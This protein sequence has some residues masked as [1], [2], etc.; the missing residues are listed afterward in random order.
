MQTDVVREALK[1]KVSKEEYAEYLHEKLLR[2]CRKDPNQFIQSVMSWGMGSWIPQGSLHVKW[3]NALTTGGKRVL[4]ICPRDHAKTSQVAIGRVLWELGNNPDLRI[5]IVCQSDDTAVKRLSAIIDHIDRNPRL[6]EVFPDL[7]PSDK[8]T[9]SK[10]KVYV[11]RNMILPD[12]SIEAVG[13]LSTATGGRGDLLIFD[14][15]VDFRNAIQQPALREVVKAAY[16]DVWVNLIEPEGRIVLIGTPWHKDDL[17]H[18]IMTDKTYTKIIDRIDDKFTPIWPEK[19]NT[20]A[21]VNRYNEIGHRA[22]GRAFRMEALTD[23]ETLFEEKI[24]KRC[25]DK[26]FQYGGLPIGVKPH[27]VQYFMGVDLGG[28]RTTGGSYTVI[29]TGALVDGKRLPINITRGRFKSPEFSRIFYDLTQQFNP[30]FVLIENNASQEAVVQWISEV[31]GDGVLLP[32]IKGYF[33]GSQK[34]SE[35]VGLPAMAVE[36]EQGR[37]RLPEFHT[38]GDCGCGYCVWLHEMKEFPLGKYSDT[39]M[40]SWL[41][42]EAIRGYGD[43]EPRISTLNTYKY[44]KQYNKPIS[45]IEAIVQKLEKDDDDDD[46]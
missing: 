31:Y 42:R 22:F 29:F 12:P 5:K 27:K 35:D 37:W 6:R 7:L 32:T 9:W 23:E 16:R 3:Q 18:H 34:M 24:L 19:W 14:D 38:E 21:L 17:L 39:V 40:A 26:D 30:E 36:F 1:R 25:E 10:T 11:K 8:G 43:R 46:N 41:F 20:E 28:A 33:T 13:I 45:S 44:K 4:M 2:T 15:P